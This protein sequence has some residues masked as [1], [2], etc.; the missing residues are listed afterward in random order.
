VYQTSPESYERLN[1]RIEELLGEFV[2]N[3][4]SETN[5]KKVKDYMHK[6][7][8]ENLRQNGYWSGEMYY[9]TKLGIDE[10]TDYEK[11]LDSITTEDV[12]KAIDN[13]LKQRNQTRVIMYGATK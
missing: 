7:Y 8:Q 10:V 9:W 13:I 6:T 4:P 2:Q 3:G 1:K 11:V 5:M 12:R